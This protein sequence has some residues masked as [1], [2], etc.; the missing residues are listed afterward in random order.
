VEYNTFKAVGQKPRVT[1]PNGDGVISSAINEHVSRVVQVN[2][3]FL[4]IGETKK[5]ENIYKHN[6]EIN[7]PKK[8]YYIYRFGEFNHKIITKFNAI[9]AGCGRIDCNIRDLFL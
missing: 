3:V 9:F 5:E 1:V 2:V 4:H 7:H 6:R 8:R